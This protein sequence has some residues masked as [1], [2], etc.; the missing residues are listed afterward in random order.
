MLQILTQISV[1]LFDFSKLYLNSDGSQR[2]GFTSFICERI[3]S[4][5]W[6][7][8]ILR[9]MRYFTQTSAGP[10]QHPSECLRRVF[11]EQVLGSVCYVNE[12]ELKRMAAECILFSFAILLAF[13]E[14]HFDSN[15]LGCLILFPVLCL[16]TARVSVPGCL[17]SHMHRLVISKHRH[18]CLVGV[19][20]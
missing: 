6:H 8:K 11:K 7:W 2:A 17:H 4:S 5:S 9:Q 18:A 13:S 19:I 3:N 15:K 20:S 1:Y 12:P 10:W 16:N 14:H